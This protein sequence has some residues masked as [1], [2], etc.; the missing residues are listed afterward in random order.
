MPGTRPQSSR[1]LLAAAAAEHR[2]TALF[3]RRRTAAP[4]GAR[5][6]FGS[7]LNRVSRTIPSTLLACQRSQKFLRN[8]AGC[9]ENKKERGVERADRSHGARRCVTEK[10]WKGLVIIF[11]KL[12]NSEHGVHS[13]RD[14][15]SAGPHDHE[16]RGNPACVT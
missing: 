4:V 5:Q 2:P 11:G 10:W 8:D 6:C 13:Q 16:S 9:V 1:H 12:P 14:L 3:S 15:F 7:R